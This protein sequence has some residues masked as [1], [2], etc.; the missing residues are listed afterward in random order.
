MLY[1]WIV[2]SFSYW[3]TSHQ[4]ELQLLDLLLFLED[5]RI[6]SNILHHEGLPEHVLGWVTCIMTVLA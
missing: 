3:M 6:A 2:P 4:P 1:E 5:F